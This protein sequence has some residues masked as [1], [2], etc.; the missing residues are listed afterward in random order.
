MKEYIY[1]TY[2]QQISFRNTLGVVSPINSSSNTRYSINFDRLIPVLLIGLLCEFAGLGIGDVYITKCVVWI[3]G[4]GDVYITKCVALVCGV[5][6]VYY[7]MCIV[8]VCAVGMSTLLGVLCG[9]AGLGMS[10]LLSVF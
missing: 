9:Y 6:D 5:G 7:T 10:T 4:V 8:W 3:C 2:L 1:Y